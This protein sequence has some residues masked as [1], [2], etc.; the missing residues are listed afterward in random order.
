MVHELKKVRD[1]WDKF[2]F[3]MTKQQKSYGL[4]ILVMTLIGAVVETLGI[5]IIIP[6]V[7]AMLEP[8]QL[9][10]NKYIGIAVDL[11]EIQ[12]SEQLILFLGIM[13]AL[14]YIFKNLYLTLLTYCRIRYSTKIQR[15]LSVL[16]MKSYMK[17]G[18]LFFV[19]VNTSDLLRGIMGDVSA[20]Y[21]MMYHSFRVFAEMSTSLAII[22]FL[23]IRNIGMALSVIVLAGVCFVAVVLG[24]RKPMQRLGVQYRQSNGEAQKHSLQAFQ[25]IKEVIVMHRQQ[26]FVNRYE[27]AFERQQKALIGQTVASESPAY[28]IEAVCVAGLILTVSFMMYGGMDAETFI[29]QL[30]A[31]AV[32]AFRILP[33][34]GRITSSFNQIIYFIP[35]LNNTY[36]HLKEVRTAEQ[37]M[38]KEIQILTQD[39]LK[40]E[41]AAGITKEQK[42]DSDDAVHKS[43]D[44][45]IVV[46][47][48]C[49]YLEVDNVHWQYPSAEKEVLSGITLHI[50]KGTSVALI[51]HSGA[52]KTTLADIILGL[53]RPQEGCI[54]YKGADIR[55]IS[56]Q[57]SN[58][59]GYIPQSVYLTDDTIRNNVAFGVDE[60]D[61]E[62][63]WQAL[64]QA[65]LK[66][67]VMGLPG[68]L[69]TIVGDRGVRFSGGQRQRVAIARALYYNPEILILDEA[70]SALDNETETAVM[71]AIDSLQGNKTLI[72]VAHRLTTIRNCDVVY[73]IADGKAM[74]RAKEE[75]FG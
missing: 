52:G 69:D 12:S 54:R 38:Q 28:I 30:S 17:R 29:P 37:E 11:F 53:Y 10:Q 15:E 25:G 21:Q 35:S 7:S 65:Q 50:H 8:D 2:Q 23:M 34:L 3:I 43:D 67:F 62:L 74:K 63:V 19:Q 32:G 42:T 5:G 48:S 51:G 33:S 4:L 14:V 75:L 57:W 46:E 66:E 27:K 59:V 58:S 70:T 22:I 45:G 24:F 49:S 20:V 13:I 47:Q 73:E 31:F 41:N 40:Q 61:D 56:E 55:T 26:F 60:P 71:A 39:D 44:L 16:M 9:L 6:F 36:E 1:I 72:I 18:Y 64:E 68:R